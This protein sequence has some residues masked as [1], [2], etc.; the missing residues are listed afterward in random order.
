MLAGVSHLWSDF[1]QHS[2]DGEP[3]VLATIVGT[4][5]STYKKPGAMM[6][7]TGDGVPAGLLSGGCLEDDIAA[8]ARRVLADGKARLIEYDLTDD[9]PFGLGLGCRGEVEIML[10][11]LIESNRYEPFSLLDPTP[12]A[13]RPGRLILGTEPSVLGQYAYQA[14]GEQVV[15]NHDKAALWLASPA[16]LGRHAHSLTEPRRLIFDL[17]P[18][19][20]ILQLGAGVDAAPVC[21]LCRDLHWHV[22]V[23]DHRAGL[24]TEQRFPGMAN[25]VSGKPGELEQHLNLADFDA[26]IVMSH[27]IDHDE[28]YLSQ[29]ASQPT[30]YVGLLG[31]PSR[32]DEIL[33]KLG[34]E[35]ANALSGRLHAPVGLDLGGRSPESIALSIVSQL[36]AV[37]HERPQQLAHGPQ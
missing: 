30:P 36:H 29:L 18:P 19:P 21:R 31:P 25:L 16:M 13:A 12:G 14:E 23:Y 5:G 20:R 11:A 33:G 35:K 34:T 24:L 15:A 17:K 9:S 4:K 6:L 3:L 8:H 10:S 2:R 28:A 37:L 32:R 7:V 22:T 26:A 27:N 1:L